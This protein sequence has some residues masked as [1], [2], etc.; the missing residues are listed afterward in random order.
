MSDFTLADELQ[1]DNPNTRVALGD[2]FFAR[3]EYSRAI[4]FYNAALQKLPEH[5]MAICRRGISFY[6]KRS[7]AEASEIRSG[8]QARQKHSQHR[9]ICGHGEEKGQKSILSAKSLSHAR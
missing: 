7:F 1:P 2:L 8:L 6:Y 3:K 4:E 5:P 9:D